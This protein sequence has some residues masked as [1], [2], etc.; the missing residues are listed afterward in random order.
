MYVRI[1]LETHLWRAGWEDARLAAENI[2][3]PWF[4]S[5]SVFSFHNCEPR[6]LDH[7]ISKV[8]INF[9]ISGF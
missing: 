6:G 1:C 3:L 4:S 5:F 8:S 7:M 2:A 9:N